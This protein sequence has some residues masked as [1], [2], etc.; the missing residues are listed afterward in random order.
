MGCL[1]R[2]LSR[3]V[4]HAVLLSCLSRRSLALCIAL[5]GLKGIETEPNSLCMA[6]ESAALVGLHG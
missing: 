6:K 4:H 1:S 2:P 5:H 3:A